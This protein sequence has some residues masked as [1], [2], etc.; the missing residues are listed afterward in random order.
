M[1]DLPP[2][3]QPY[4]SAALFHGVLAA[5][6]V[7]V[8]GLSGGDLGK[9]LAVAAGYFVLATGWSWWRFRQRA[10]RSSTGSSTRG[11]EGR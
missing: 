6:I 1:S 4:R 5:L 3:P 11:G 7:L 2:P 9:A 10:D 8:A